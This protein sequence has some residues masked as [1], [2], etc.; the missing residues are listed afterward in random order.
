MVPQWTFLL[1]L[2][3]TDHFFIY[4]GVLYILFSVNSLFIPFGHVS[5][6]FLVLLGNISVQVS[7]GS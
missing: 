5:V 2:S 1:T 6:E 7:M 3:D 4:V